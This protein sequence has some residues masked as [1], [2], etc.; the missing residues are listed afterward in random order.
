[1]TAESIR[2]HNAKMEPLVGNFHTDGHATEEEACECYKNYMLDTQLSLMDKEPAN[3]TQ[4]FKCKACGAWTACRA[5]VGPYQVF[6]L[7][8]QHQTREEVEKLFSVG[9]S[10]QS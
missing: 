3:A 6:D 10:W 4:Q 2:A 5:M 7:C 1:M 8:P 9:E